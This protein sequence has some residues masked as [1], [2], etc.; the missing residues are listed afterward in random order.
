MGGQISN[1]NKHMEIRPDPM[2]LE[3]TILTPAINGRKSIISMEQIHQQVFHLIYLKI[4]MITIG[5]RY[6]VLS[7]IHYYLSA[8]LVDPLLGKIHHRII[9]MIRLDWQPIAVIVR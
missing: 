1:N 3:I 9:L 5:N 7:F 8:F 2:Q 6:R 4:P